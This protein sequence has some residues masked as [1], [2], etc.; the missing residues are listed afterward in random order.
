[1]R[2][3]GREE[4]QLCPAWSGLSSVSGEGIMNLIPAGFKEQERAEVFISR[5][6]FAAFPVTLLSCFLDEKTETP[7]LKKLDSV[8]QEE[9]EVS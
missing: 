4:Q 5:V 9:F 8:E 7:G 3:P 1:M 2:C 6:S